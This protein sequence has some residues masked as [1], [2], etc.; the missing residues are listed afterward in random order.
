MF[1]FDLPAVRPAKNPHECCDA[2]REAREIKCVC[3]C[4]GKNHGAAN[5]QD[6]QPLDKALGFE[7]DAAGPLEDLALDLELSGRLESP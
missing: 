4:G 1:A 2:C 7:K 6:M 5:R 3:T